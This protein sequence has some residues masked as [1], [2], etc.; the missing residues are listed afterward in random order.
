MRSIA[1]LAT[2]LCAF[3]LPSPGRADDAGEIRKLVPAAAAM[4]RDDLKKLATSDAPMPADFESQNLTLT[5][6][7][8]PLTDDKRL[9]AE[10][11]YLGD[12]PPRP[13][14]LAAEISRQVGA[15]SFSVPL[16]P[17]TMIHADR[18]KDVT[19]KVAG[20]AA[21]GTIK[22]EVPELYAGQIDYL[23]RKA[24]DRWQIVEFHLPARDIHLALDERG[25]WKR[26]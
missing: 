21:R 8:L 2:F 17:A 19:C 7:S 25:V 22:F 4:P 10:F 11:R 24:D 16:G 15:G 14:K 5:L 20:D 26:K 6:L 18:I 1:L 9:L 12:G 23:A 13:S 3:A